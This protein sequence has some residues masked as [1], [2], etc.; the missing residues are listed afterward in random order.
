MF[1]EM[2]VRWT[3]RLAVACYV[4]RLMIDSRPGDR[5]SRQRIARWW[6][7]IGCA[8]F[9]LHVIA[10]FHFTHHWNHSAAFE[11]TARRTAEMTGWN[12]GVGLY[13]NEAF[14]CLWLTDT[15]LWWRDD[16]W[17][18]HRR[19]YW[20]IQ[21]IFAFLFIQATVVFGPP[22]WK[23]MAMLVVVLFLAR[24]LKRHQV[25]D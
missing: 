24:N 16:S 11:S 21:G 15:V 7:T 14:L 2:I 19:I 6:W 25:P 8:W 3:A 12:S 5:I 10:A 17:P 22:F 9:L 23:P 20:T 4:A 18:D 1:E 13:I